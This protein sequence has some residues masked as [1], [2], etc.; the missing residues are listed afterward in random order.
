MSEAAVRPA[1]EG[2][3]LRARWERRWA[4]HGVVWLALIAATLIVVH[5]VLSVIGGHPGFALLLAIPAA[6]G[7]VA[8]WLAA[9]H[10]SPNLAGHLLVATAAIPI[11][12]GGLATQGQV[13]GQRIGLIAVPVLAVLFVGSIGRI[14][15]TVAALGALIFLNGVANAAA[16]PPRAFFAD[17]DATLRVTLLLIGF[18]A[19]AVTL[20]DRLHRA[21]V[22]R[23]A[24]SVARLGESEERYRRLVD[25][26][27][28]AVCVTRE[29]RVVV[30]NRAC[31]ELLRIDET[32][33]I[34]GSDATQW[35]D[36]DAS[37]AIAAKRPA[38]YS[39]VLRVSQVPIRI[40]RADGSVAEAELTATPI[41]I[42][43][44][45]HVLNVIRDRTA[46]HATQRK[47]AMLGDAIDRSDEGVFIVGLDSRIVYANEGAKV[48]AG[49]DPDAMIGVRID[50]AFRPIALRGAIEE[51]V[52][53]LRRRGDAA[54]RFRLPDR[55][56]RERSWDTRAFLARNALGDP[57]NVVVLVRDASLEVELER[58]TLQN[59]KLE[60]IGRLAG[61]IA[62][63]FNNYLTAMVGHA[64]SI[65]GSLP[66]EH[67]ARSE[68]VGI[69]DAA[70]RS[71]A[72]TQQLLAVGRQQ[73]LEERVV[74]A[75]RVARDIER[76]L[77]K[78]LPDRIALSLEL[79]DRVPAIVAD[80]TRIEQVLLNLVV[81]A[82][83]AIPGEGRI[84]LRT[85]SYEEGD[86][87]GEAVVIEVEDD[88]AGIA[89]TDLS[90]I[91]D[92]FFSTKSGGT[93]LGLAT[94][95]GIVHQSGGEVRVAR[96]GPEGTRI[97]VLLPVAQTDRAIAPIDAPMPTILLVEDEPSVRRLARRALERE[98]F[99]ILEASDGREA[100]ELSASYDGP[101][102][103]LVSDLMMPEI[104]GLELSERIAESRPGTPVLFISGYSEAREAVRDALRGQGRFLAKPFRPRELAESVRE[105]IA[106][107]QAHG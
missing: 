23:S 103:L 57:E 1:G 19:F 38:L 56:G 53:Q 61:G 106:R 96:S 60:A 26:L 68:A 55:T 58:R 13:S 91:F 14:A 100:L 46:E 37:D 2:T 97:E 76:T 65:L 32:E 88:G 81:N 28:D 84:V 83:D 50:E 12:L 82:R 51:M 86:A 45:P 31:T 90:R 66:E 33:E 63:D 43:G 44:I 4:R 72:L 8:A 5:A 25:L 73:E 24:R 22:D 77:A 18:V 27:P 67:A 101:I 104:G 7:L 102:S 79:A 9:T 30:A 40:H 20:Y 34:V 10:R 69:L 49:L 99:Q 59:Q 92:P 36:R 41:S 29:G 48:L 93:G 64:E 75:N 3:L 21:A 89:E 54:S 94:V 70:E 52:E 80:R 11:V 47:V 74:D 87:A 35:I 6:F 15:W 62:H 85:H 17:P 78:L 39:G 71:A 107:R 95:Q 16:V 42:D 98:G 105:L